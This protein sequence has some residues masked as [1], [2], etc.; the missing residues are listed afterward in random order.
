MI[1]PS[2]VIGRSRRL[3]SIVSGCIG[4]FGPTDEPS[5]AVN[6]LG[7]GAPVTPPRIFVHP[8]IAQSLTS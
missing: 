7:E 5:Q 2:Q 1:V 8:I 4:E 6:G 3:S